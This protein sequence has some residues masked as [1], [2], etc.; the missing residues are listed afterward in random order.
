MSNRKNLL[1]TAKPTSSETREMLI[2]FPSW[3]STGCCLAYDPSE[4][5]FLLDHST[6]AEEQCFLI[7]EPGSD[8][9]HS[10]FINNPA[11]LP[12]HL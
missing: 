7:M 3:S 4:A 8:I 10:P 6:M 11:A 9:H 2:P 1:Q 5:R 12:R